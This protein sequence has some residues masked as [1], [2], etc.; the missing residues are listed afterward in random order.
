MN[1]GIITILFALLTAGCNGGDSNTIKAPGLVEG[2][3]ITMKSRVASKVVRINTSEGEEIT[4]GKVLVQFDSRTVN[5]KLKDIELNLRGAD[6]KLEKLNKKKGLAEKNFRYLRAQVGKFERLNRKRSVSGDDLEKMKLKLLEA[7]TSLFE[8][9]RSVEEI[10]IQKNVLENNREYLG[11]LLEDYNLTAGVQGIVMEKFISAGENV[12]PGSPVID[13]LD[14]G[15]LYVEIF[16]EEEE[17]F[18]V[19]IGSPVTIIMDGVT[20]KDL[21]GM[22]AEIGR[23]AEFSPKYVVS[24]EE[25]KSLLYKVKVKIG[26]NLEMFKIGMPVTV[27]IDKKK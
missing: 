18:A 27:L 23:K 4:P 24:E 14:T 5:N 26:G 1:K 11:I 3:I 2:E 20:G 9:T 17:L 6:L 21:K 13:L 15:S 12:F 7:E 25:R 22:V 10:N 8:I 16:I 19:N